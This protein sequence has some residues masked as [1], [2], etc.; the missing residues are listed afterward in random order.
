MTDKYGK[1]EY[2]SKERISDIRQWYRTRV[3][4][5]PFAGN[6]SKDR[7]YARTDW[8]CRCQEEKEDQMHIISGKCP[9]YSDIK[10]KYAKLERDSD[11]VDFFREVLE[12]RDLVDEMEEEEEALAVGD[13]ADV[14]LA[15]DPPGQASLAMHIV[16]D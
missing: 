16:L 4:L 1:K 15:R 10:G 11:L 12:R 2:I 7:K 14:Q 3:G 8:M 9:V 13:T 6:Y 5:L